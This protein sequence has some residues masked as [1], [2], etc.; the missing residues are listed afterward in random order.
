LRLR[1]D[2]RELQ[3]DEVKPPELQWKEECI[4]GVPMQRGGT[5]SKRLI[6]GFCNRLDSE[7][8]YSGGNI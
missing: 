2:L 1:G 8:F 3:L 6:Q 4:Q 7:E 5:S